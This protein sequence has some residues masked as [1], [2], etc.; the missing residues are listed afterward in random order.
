L[1]EFNFTDADWLDYLRAIDNPDLKDWML[2]Q[3]ARGQDYYRA[4]LQKIKFGGGRVLDAGCGVG[5]WAI[6]LACM[7][8]QVVAVE[9]DAVRLAILA[10]MASHFDGRILTELASIEALP[11]PDGSF[12][13]VFC[14]GVIFLA[15]YRRALGEFSRV[16]KPGSPLYVTYNGK[17]WW[18]HLIRDRGAAE[19]ECVI[20]GANGLISRYF[21]LLDDL[22]FER[23]ID[24]AT[25]QAVQDELLE[26]FPNDGLSWPI[27]RRVKQAYGSYSACAAER[28]SHID[29]A[30]LALAR[31]ELGR[32]DRA[33]GERR[34]ATDALACLYDLCAAGIPHSYKERIARDLVSRMAIGRSEYI[35]EIHTYAHEPEEMSEEFA[36]HGFHMIQSAHEG[37][38]CL[39]PSGA[40]V[41]PLYDLRMNVFE[42][43]AWR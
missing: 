33:P 9:N 21:M 43:I 14:N 25:A 4:R 5:N 15:D 29:E 42:S 13:A 39:D 16:L 7:F 30:A 19:P 26:E 36:R 3:A 27:E 38:L 40:S 34:K 18:R 23:K 24:G 31:R 35:Q 17:G 8:E 32:S 41:R 2:T 10:G 22:S 28:R 37:C 20:Y 6:A 11:F 1:R 12:D